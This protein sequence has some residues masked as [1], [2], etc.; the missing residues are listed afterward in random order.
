[1][2][3]LLDTACH[4]ARK[5]GEYI[6]S[7]ERDLDI[8]FKAANNPVTEADRASEKL[9]LDALRPRFPGHLFL[10]EEEAAPVP[11]DSEKLWIIDPV[12][13]TNNFSRGI[14][15]YCVSIAYA[16]KGTVRA[17][18]IFDPC[19]NEMF[20]AAAGEGA[21]LNGCPIRVSSSRSLDR[22]IIATG[23]YYD[24]GRMMEKTLEAMNRLYRN[25]VGGIRRMGSAA[26]DL[27]WTACGRYDGFFEYRLSP[28]DYAAGWLIVLEA[29]GTASDR[30]GAPLAL[31]SNSLIASNG[32]LGGAFESAV[33]WI[34]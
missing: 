32:A 3:A 34:D 29:G 1:M 6:V 27:C 33:R 22:A 16:E 15:H 4:I 11:L 12:D 23:F 24:R 20:A 18:A 10:S 25:K 13:G 5:A 8:R 28:W 2:N 30:S 26:L 7:F 21:R 31:T 17:A 9:I 19:R 14:P